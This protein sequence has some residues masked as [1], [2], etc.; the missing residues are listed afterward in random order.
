MLISIVNHSAKVHDGRLQQVIRAI[1]R[2]L[3]EDF[4]PYW[5]RTARL[6]LEGTS[7]A[8]PRPASASDMRG[9]AV[10]YL[11]R[12]PGEEDDALGYHEIN[13][14]GIAYGFVFTKLC[15]DLGEDWSITLSHEA[16]ELVLDP[17]ANLLVKGPHP[18]DPT[19]EVYHWYE[20]CDA[21]QDDPY[22]IDGVEV[23]NFVLP[24]YFTTR[25]EHGGRNDFLGTRRA[26]PLLPSFGVAPGGYIG[27]YDPEIGDD[28]NHFADR[29][30]RKRWEI[31]RKARLTRRGLRY[32]RNSAPLAYAE[33]D[34][35]AGAPPPELEC[36][37]ITAARS[38]GAEAALRAIVRKV[39]GA[40]WTIER[41]SGAEFDLVPPAAVKPDAARAFELAY[42]LR[43]ASGI[44]RA[45]P[46]FAVRMP[47]DE[48]RQEVTAA[49]LR[50]L[51][52]ASGSA[53]TADAPSDP[54]WSIAR[55]GVDDAW[56]LLDDESIG[57][58]AGIRIGHP[59]TGFTEH[60]EILGARINRKLDVDFVDGDADAIDPLQHGPLLNPGH[61]TGTASVIVSPLGADAPG[62]ANHVSGV[63]PAAELV[64]MRVSRSVVQHSMRNL[65]D[66][67]DHAVANR[68]HVIS[69]SLG[70]LPSD[71]LHE[72]IRRAEAAGVIVLAAAGNYVRLVVW[73]ARYPEV[74]AVAACDSEGRAWSGS[75][76]GETVDITGPGED[77]YRAYW[78]DVDGVLVPQVGP[79]SGTSYA[80]ATVAGVAALWLAYHGRDAL[81]AKYP[82]ALLP[83]VFRKLVAETCQSDLPLPADGFGPGV[84]DAGALL[85]AKLPATS[86]LAARGARG[87][88]RRGARASA[89]GAQPS[90]LD[91]LASLFP[92]CPPAVARE[93]FAE[94]LGASGK[95]LEQVAARYGDE[96]LFRIV[97]DPALHT[98]ING[99]LGRVARAETRAARRLRAADPTAHAR[100][101]SVRG[102]LTA[103]GLSRDLRAQLWGD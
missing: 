37:A 97:L 61:G 36:I 48:A 94:I 80:V 103:V 30:A 56:K 41:R 25:E 65:R 46:L 98:T 84:V 89:A 82:G 19:R 66:A 64:P 45:E 67:I 96:L 47:D 31:K 81:L 9:E 40:G 100:L 79:S 91:R 99:H 83:A 87:R 28:Q 8:E 71:T 32:R 53:V 39:L 35:G 69:I 21:V 4:A 5:S 52:R 27:F 101:R 88:S 93:G 102:A 43:A 63:A 74:V 3:Q 49:R 12:E 17:E 24:L 42:R 14:R 44:A 58:G 22:R 7:Q 72:A 68:C 16:L 34:V 90:P 75:S 86:A 10:I 11:C 20:A 92:T 6:R 77:V 26:R 70:G 60:A 18:T 15:Q 73:P 1:N 50:G 78:D 85:R 38:R 55:A 23:A 62:Y 29:R 95:Q 51:L 57:H 13:H 54:D 2:Q 59:D 76:R 33:Q